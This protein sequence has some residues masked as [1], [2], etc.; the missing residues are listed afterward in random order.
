MTPA[1]PK[2]VLAAA[3]A[4]GAAPVFAGTQVG[5][6]LNFSGFGTLGLTRTDTDSSDFIRDAEAGGATKDVSANVDSNFG[7]QLTGTATPWLSATVQ[8]LSAERS[9]SY[10]ATELEWAFVKV[11]PLDGLTLRGGRMALPVFAVSD[12]RNV[13]YANNWLRPPGEVYGLALISRLDGADASYSMALGSSTLTATAMAGKSTL[14]KRNST[15]L[16]T[17]N[18][19]GL[20]LLWETEG[21][22][23]RLGQVRTR[24]HPSAVAVDV[25]VHRCGRPGRSRQHRR[26]SRIRDPSLGRQRHPYQRRWMVCH[27]RLSIRDMAALR[28]LRLDQ[29]DHRRQSPCRRPAGH[30]RDRCA[31]GCTEGDGRQVPA[32]T[33]RHEGHSRHQLHLGRHQARHRRQRH[34]RLRV[35]RRTTT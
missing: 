30:D 17:D 1:F 24:V 28:V 34:R 29:A 4:L 12:S 2:A 23:V 27:G 35:L 8:M 33:H 15:D 10:M 6:Y 26:A 19:R 16:S 5:D 21:V 22:T 20:N 18:L 32:R 13:G 3:L 14:P 7:L 25:Q 9:Q 11:T 31:L